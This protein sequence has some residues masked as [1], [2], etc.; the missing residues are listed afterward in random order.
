MVRSNKVDLHE[1]A[2]PACRK[3]RNREERCQDESNGFCD[4]ATSVVDG[5]PVRCVGD[6]AVQKL[7]FLTQ[8]VGIFG[9]GMK[10]KWGGHIQYVEI[11]SG[12]GRCLMRRSGIE[13]DGTPLAVLQHPAFASFETATFLDFDTKVVAA[14]NDRIRRLGLQSK[15]QA[16]EADYNDAASVLSGPARQRP[17]QHP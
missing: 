9:P 17:L 2:N 7:H 11:C 5:G 12:P 10:A 8:Y 3:C 15:A 14:V 16:L 4:E 13:I 1:M 6:W